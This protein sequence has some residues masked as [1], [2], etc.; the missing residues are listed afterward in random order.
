MSTDLGKQER[1]GRG[2]TA[3]GAVGVAIMLWAGFRLATGGNLTSPP[4]SA[5]WLVGGA[6]VHDVLIAPVACLVSTLLARLL[7]TPTRTV[8]Q[9]G[10]AI[11]AILTLLAIPV[12]KSPHHANETVLPRDYTTG[13]VQALLVVGAL[14]VVLAVEAER[15][16]RS[17]AAQR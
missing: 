10:L 14:T 4:S 11:A 13:L 16:R 5:K 17:A 8:V 1:I 9:A 2:R 3:V 12:L 7:P 15:R 6:L